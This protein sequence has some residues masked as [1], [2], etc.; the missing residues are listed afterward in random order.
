MYPT[1]VEHPQEII[2]LKRH[3]HSIS[4]DIICT[5][6]L[7]EGERYTVSG[8]IRN[9]ILPLIY[10]SQDRAKTDRGTITLKL[11]HNAERF[12]GKF[13]V[14]DTKR[15]SIGAS[16]VM[17][18]R[19]KEKLEK[20]LDGV[21]QRDKSVEEFRQ[22]EEDVEEARKEI[23]SVADTPVTSTPLKDEDQQLEEVSS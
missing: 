11:V 16:D 17:W 18:F 3:G 10:E 22:R 20:F 8:S 2:A 6:G 19:S 7:D 1:T 15:D 5:V 4:G 23:T 12:S 9:M 21:I 13:A 14:Y